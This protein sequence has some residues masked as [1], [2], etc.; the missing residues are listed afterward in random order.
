M[1]TGSKYLYTLRNYLKNK[2][3]MSKCSK[4]QLSPDYLTCRVGERSSKNELFIYKC[5]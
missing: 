4:I 3:A 5:T 1:C 2:I